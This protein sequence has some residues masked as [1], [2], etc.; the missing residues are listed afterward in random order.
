MCCDA[1]S[2]FRAELKSGQ[3]NVRPD[4][5]D[6]EYTTMKLALLDRIAIN[7]AAELK[8]SK[9]EQDLS[10]G[11]TS[12]TALASTVP[13]LAKL[14]LMAAEAI[15]HSMQQLVD[16]VVQL[17]TADLGF[18]TGVHIHGPG[19]KDYVYVHSFYTV[20]GGEKHDLTL[21]L[22]SVAPPIS[23]FDSSSIV[24]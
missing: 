7:N 1:L 5:L 10:G 9:N 12:P 22:R 13:T 3:V 21:D 14:T 4:P 18:F 15:A 17:D 6:V 19:G 8:K 20:V 2:R 24:S 11:A 16:A 23:L